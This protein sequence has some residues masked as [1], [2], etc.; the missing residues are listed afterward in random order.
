MVGVINKDLIFEFNNEDGLCRALAHYGNQNGCEVVIVAD[1]S[2]RIKAI[3][4]K[5]EFL[6][7]PDLSEQI[8]YNLYGLQSALALNKEQ[9]QRNE[10]LPLYANW[11]LMTSFIYGY[12]P[13]P[14]I[15][16]S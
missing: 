4:Y 14:T 11:E 12:V 8:S 10:P 7:T 2:D 1:K 15:I 5:G 3:V 6:F 9:L 13:L 16:N